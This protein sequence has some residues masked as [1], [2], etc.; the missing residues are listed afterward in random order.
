MGAKRTAFGT[1]G[2]A[3]RNTTQTQLQSIAAKAALAA[4]NVDPQHVDTVVIGHIMTVIHPTVI[5]FMY[6]LILH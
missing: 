3:F 6:K 4:S 2:G 1:F 5:N